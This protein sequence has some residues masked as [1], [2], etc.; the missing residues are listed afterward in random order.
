VP[1]SGTGRGRDGEEAGWVRAR[2]CVQDGAVEV[3]DHGGDLVRRRHGRGDGAMR[4]RGRGMGRKRGGGA[5]DLTVCL[6]AGW[7]GWSH[8]NP[9]FR[10]DFNPP[11]VWLALLEWV[12]SNS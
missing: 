10:D 9:D 12:G 6:V 7:V 5:G 4:R 8:S 1:A 2:T 11:H 3:E